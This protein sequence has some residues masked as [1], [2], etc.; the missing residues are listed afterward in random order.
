VLAGPRR[1][2]GGVISGVD[3]SLHVQVRQPA[4][5]LGEYCCLPAGGQGSPWSVSV[6]VT[7]S[8]PGA[9]T[10]V[11]STGGHYAN[12]ER[13]AITGLRAG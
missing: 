12:I 13:F 2:V 4:G 1:A 7:S 9:V 5:L 6:P 3:E 10:V 8:Q 11:V